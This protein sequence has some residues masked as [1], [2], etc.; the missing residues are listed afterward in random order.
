MVRETNSDDRSPWTERGFVAAAAL[1]GFIVVLAIVFVVSGGGGDDNGRAQTPTSAP[2]SPAP[3]A[4]ACGLPDGGQDVPSSTPTDTRWELVG[5]MAAPTEPDR[6]GPGRV[7]DGVRT[8]F[9]RSPIGALYAAVNFWAENT[10]TPSRVVLEQLAAD[11][12]AKDAAIAEAEAQGDALRLD[13]ATKMQLAGFTFRAY[14]R[15]NVTVDLAFRVENG[16]LFHVPTVLRWEGG[17]WK[18]VVA[19]N[20]NF[21][22]GEI[23]DLSGYVPWKGA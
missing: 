20:G 16:G 13:D 22:A 1:I 3:G 19:P 15:N 8:C 14:D 6:H 12:P 23:A 4:S 21:G 5:S 9:A 11:T 17:D 7:D 10:D 18:Y 2:P